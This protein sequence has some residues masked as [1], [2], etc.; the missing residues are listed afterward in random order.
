MKRRRHLQSH[1]LGF[2]V[3]TTFPSLTPHLSS[4]DDA[5]AYIVT[6]K[7]TRCILILISV[8]MLDC[9]VQVYVF[10]RFVGPDPKALQKILLIIRNRSI[11]TSLCHLC[12]V[13]A[14]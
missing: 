8:S 4:G 9:K 13:E 1:G 3:T 12:K 14:W 6:A 5:R 7:Y 10:L 11:I 2:N